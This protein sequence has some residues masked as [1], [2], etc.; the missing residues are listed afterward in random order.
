MIAARLLVLASISGSITQWISENGVYAV[1]ALMALDALL[2][3]GGE[4]VMLFAGAVASGGVA[5]GH[6]SL[7]GATLASGGESYVV[8]SLAG[9]L[10]YLVGAIAG[11]AIGRYGGRP[12]VERHGR[13]LHVGPEAL[14]R[15]E[16]WFAR[17]GLSAVLLGRI[18]PVVRSFIS[19]PAGVFG[20]A[21]APYTALTLVGS[22]IWCFSFAGAGWALGGSW[23]SFHKGFG[24]LDLVVV[25]AIAIAIALLGMR[26]MRRRRLTAASRSDHQPERR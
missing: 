25:V 9:T 12:L 1:F 20:V 16:R 8:L 2:P 13:R 26:W 4:L 7:F 21:L 15:A 24:Y 3:V 14:A 18:T 5:A 17:F 19:I 6:A 22:A 10:G 23:E 11:W